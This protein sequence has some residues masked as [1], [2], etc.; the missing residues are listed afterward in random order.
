MYIKESILCACF[1]IYN[2]WVTSK[3]NLLLSKFLQIV[4]D[5]TNTFCP[6]ADPG[7]WLTP[8]SQDLPS[9]IVSRSVVCCGPTIPRIFYL[10]ILFIIIVFKERIW[11]SLFLALYLTPSL[12]SL[13]N[14]A[15]HTTFFSN[16]M[17]RIYG[18]HI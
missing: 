13:H 7:P 8:C 15:Y 1:F 11:Y 6:I 16:N 14:S 5:I 10:K 4:I 12:I 2:H 9:H 18:T 17:G 3:K